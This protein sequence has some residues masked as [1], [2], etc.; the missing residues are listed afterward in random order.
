MVQEDLCCGMGM[1]GWS[2]KKIKVWNIGTLPYLGKYGSDMDRVKNIISDKLGLN[3][4]DKFIK[5]VELPVGVD[6]EVRLLLDEKGNTYIKIGA[7][8]GWKRYGSIRAL[9][10]MPIE[11]VV[12]YI[13]LNEDKVKE[14]L[15]SK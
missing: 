9:F 11:E 4:R 8:H 5:Y 6:D 2:T 12:K 14:I 3:K 1:R 7:Y 10:P 13:R 15:L